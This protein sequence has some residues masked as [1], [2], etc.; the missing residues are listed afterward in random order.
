MKIRQ[1]GGRK[2]RIYALAA[3]LVLALG[4]AVFAGQALAGRLTD[5]TYGNTRSAPSVPNVN[6]VVNGN[7]ETG[8]IS[9]WTTAVNGGTGGINSNPPFVHAG[10]FSGRITTAVNT[11]SSGLG[12]GGNC[13]GGVRIPVSPNTSYTWSGYILVP[14]G[15]ANF[16]SA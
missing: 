16:S 12:G 14:T 1:N 4:M 2:L 6:M 3:I 7:F 9:P 15:T 13:A 10:S 8:S 5:T 11:G